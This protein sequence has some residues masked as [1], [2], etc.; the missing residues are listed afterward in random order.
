MNLHI[1]V[2]S[3]T[4][5]TDGTEERQYNE[6]FSYLGTVSGNSI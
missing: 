5:K 4:L 2:E 1:S 6:M 3:K